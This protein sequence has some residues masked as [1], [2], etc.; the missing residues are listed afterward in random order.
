[1]K[2]LQEFV[3]VQSN[4]DHITIRLDEAGRICPASYPYRHE[5]RKAAEAEAT[6]LAE[7]NPGTKF[8]VWSRVT[9]RIADVVRILP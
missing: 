6:R 9:G 1:M 3:P 5:S 7:I 2:A 8:E 4:G